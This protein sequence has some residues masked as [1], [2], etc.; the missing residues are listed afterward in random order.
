MFSLRI[1]ISVHENAVTLARE[2]G[3]ILDEITGVTV[4]L[5]EII[6]RVNNKT[7]KN[8]LMNRK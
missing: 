6:C 2:N 5:F 1:H 7:F 4:W 8:L 3:S